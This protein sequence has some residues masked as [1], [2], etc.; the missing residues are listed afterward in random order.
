MMLPTQIK[1]PNVDEAPTID[2]FRRNVKQRTIILA[3]LVFIFLMVAPF[4]SHKNSAQADSVLFPRIANVWGNYTPNIGPGFFARYNL[5]VTYHVADPVAITAIRATNPGIKIL[6]TGNATYGWPDEDALTMSWMGAQPGTPEYACL[7][8][9]SHGNILGRSDFG[10]PMYNMTA[11]Y[12]VQALVQNNTSL[13]QIN[14]ASYDGLFWDAL[15]NYIYETLAPDIDANLDGHPDDAATLDA[16]YKA[17]VQSFLIQ[18]RANLPNAIFL[19]NGSP[20]DYSTWINGNFMEVQLRRILNN[21]PG[22]T[23]I[24]TVN[25]YRA[26]C[27]VTTPPCLTT[28][29]SAPEDE[30]I[31]KY[32]YNDL[33]SI[34]A[35]MEAEAAANY[36]HMRFGLATT[37]MG[38]G[39]Y[40]FDWGSKWHGNLWWYDEYGSVSSTG[41]PGGYL[42]VPTSAPTLINDQLASP[43]LITNGDFSSGLTNWNF[44]TDSNAN[45]TPAGSLALD[46]TGGTSGSPAARVNVALVDPTTLRVQLYQNNI[47]TENGKSYTLSFWARSEQ[48]RTI[49]IALKKQSSPWNSYGFR[50]TAQI[51]PQWQQFHLLGISSATASDGMLQFEFRGTLGNVWI[52]DLQFQE[53]ALGV[54]ARSFTGGIA[55]VNTTALVQT[56]NLPGTFRKING[57]QAPLWQT[58]VDDDMAISAGNWSVSTANLSQFGTTTHSA[59]APDPAATLTYA[60]RIT[61]NGTYEIFAWIVPSAGQSQA[62]QVTIHHASGQSTVLLNEAAGD[63]GWHSLGSYNLSATGDSSVVIAVTG[64]GTV[65]ADAIKWVSAARF[66]DGSLV[67]QITMEPLDGI[68]L[69]AVTDTATP[70]V[71][72]TSTATLTKTVTTTKT[73]TSATLPTATR[74]SSKTATF[75]PTKTPTTTVTRTATLQATRTSTITATRTRTLTVTRTATQT[76][77]LT[78]TA[79]QEPIYTLAITIVG[80]GNVERSNPGP[81]HFGDIIQL[82]A[83]PSAD[84]TFTGWSGDLIGITNPISITMNGNKTVTAYF[85]QNQILP[86]N[87]IIQPGTLRENFESLVGWTASASAAGSSA[88]LD[89]IHVKVGTAAIKLTTPPGGGYI[90]ITKTVSWDLSSPTEQGAIRLWVYLSGTSEPSDVQIRM[91]NDAQ[92]QNVFTTYYNNGIKFRNRPGWN[93]INLRTSDWFTGAGTPSW[94]N[95]IVRIQIRIYDKISNAYTVDGLYSGVVARPAILF[96][97][98]NAQQSIYDQANAYMNTRNVRGTV[99]VVTDWMN[100]ANFMTWTQLQELSAEGWTVGNKT[101]SNIPLTSLTEAGQEAV[102]LAARSALNMYNL[103]NVDYVAYPGGLYNSDTLTAMANLGMRSGRTLTYFTFNLPI[104]SAFEISGKELSGSLTLATA[105]SLVDKAVNRQEVVVVTLYGLSASPTNG[106]DWYIDRF[107]ALINYCIKKGV[108]IITMDDLYRL[109]SGSVVIPGA[110]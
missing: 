50:V 89:T 83:A 18:I 87:L 84:F 104:Q 107:Q 86:Q 79:T 16:A 14:S 41:L 1:L 71:T 98:D 92:F 55:V 43:N 36:R 8:R 30:I 64:S 73:S 27:N 58:R 11:A 25:Q 19:G 80:S 53:G 40:S 94:S 109:Q 32:G 23:W 47:A 108:S 3:A 77:S 52:D 20:L 2:N 39:I 75:K 10:H 70:T 4:G 56:V 22:D 93:L 45:G 65:V 51:T 91:S 110:R 13:Y 90:S 24:E 102:F 81:Y 15:T 97:F 37:L 103:T 67:Q 69:L 28:L 106:T 101:T 17:G 96:S 99:F 61:A 57:S 12:C 60:P 46:A 38:D 7:L 44:F 31:Y 34:P 105:Q 33:A 88:V 76:P 85:T 35:A 63:I 6:L 48:T 42:G 26:W 66:N 68:I 72:A 21:R 95:P 62:V 82:T 49:T 74:T 9:D 59:S 5:Y 78:P 100:S 29:A 54:W